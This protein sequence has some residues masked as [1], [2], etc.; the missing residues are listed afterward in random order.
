VFVSAQFRPVRDE[1]RHR[2]ASFEV[3]CS[4]NNSQGTISKSLSLH[5]LNL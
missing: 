2:Q 1:N 4:C 3:S 5:L